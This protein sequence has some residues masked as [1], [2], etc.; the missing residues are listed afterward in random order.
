MKYIILGIFVLVFCR[1][2]VNAQKVY[3][4]SYKS[5]ADKIIFVTDYKSEADMIVYETKYKSEAKPYS[6]IWFWTTYK[7]E[8]DWQVYFTKYKSEANLKIYFTK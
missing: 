1:I 6:G 5:E 8:A 3:R 7:S 4:T 2:S